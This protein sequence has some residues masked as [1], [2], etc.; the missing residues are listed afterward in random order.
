[1][2]EHGT[3]DPNGK[4]YTFG[5]FCLD[6]AER[7]LT[8]GGTPVSLT[9]KA[10]DLLALLVANPGKL[11]SKGEI[12]D[13]VW[14]G[15]DT[16]ESSLTTHISMLRQALEE[17]NAREYIQT[18]PKKGYRFIANVENGASVPKISAHAAVTWHRIALGTI[19][20]V[21]IIILGFLYW[22]RTPP[23]SAS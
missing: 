20:L 5:P 21:V 18:V 4:L 10:F 6:I 13:R 14:E 23:R 17:T 15:T 1:M 12:L 11:L 9:V 19:G 2:L 8:K 3:E 16:Y 7:R 22:R